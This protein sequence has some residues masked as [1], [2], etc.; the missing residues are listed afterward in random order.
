MDFTR[1][2]EQQMLSDAIGKFVQNDYSWE[3]RREIVRQGFSP[4]VWLQFAELG[5]LCVPFSEEEGGLGGGLCDLAVVMEEFG[6]G[7]VVEPYLSTVVLGGYLVS[8]LGSE[9]QR[10]GMIPAI[11]EGR[12]R[13]ALACYEPE[14]R[15][16][17]SDV[18]TVASRDGDGWRLQGRKAVVLH[19][20]E[21]DTLVVVARTSGERYEPQGLSL[22]LVDRAADGVGVRAYP[23]VDGQRAAEIDFDG[24]AV[25][26]DALLGELDKGFAALEDAIGRAAI[27]LCAEAVGIM[28]TLLHKTVEYTKTREQF[29]QPISRFQALQH[30]MADMFIECQQARSML[31]M[32]ALHV[33]AGRGDVATLASAAKARI[34]QAARRVGQ[35]AVQL[36]GGIAVTEDFDVGHYFKRLTTICQT[37]GS[38]DWHL[39][40]Y[41]EASAAR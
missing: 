23:T 26:A 38:T 2:D 34:G 13:L 6:K 11:V 29:G 8:R 37:F 16:T 36:H 35:E 10:A 5:W 41:A 14:S 15:F 39:G 25:P 19:G 31:L 9:A 27:A 12:L 28:D 18:Q 40:R 20:G 33:D 30:R 21:A 7:L 22:F 3:R 24:V 17:L 32:A 1:S 4:E